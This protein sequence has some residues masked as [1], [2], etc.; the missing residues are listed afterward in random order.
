MIRPRSNVNV[1][2][3]L[4]RYVV[5]DKREVIGGAISNAGNLHAWCLRELRVD[6][7][8]MSRA[9]AAND[10]LTL[11]PFWVN[12]RAPTWPE[13][14][15]GVI[16]GLTQAAR[17]PQILRAATTSTFYRLAEILDLIEMSA[18]RAREIIVSG[19][20][21]HSLASLHLLADALGRDV[22]NCAELEASLH[23]AALHG[24]KKLGRSVSS[25][26]KGKT[27]RHNRA[28]AVQHRQRRERQIALE[29]LLS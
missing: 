7:I 20:G 27:I 18:G 24:L 8:D 25:T 17:A 9:A 5:D 23:G 3:G 15:Q 28:L 19:G 26:T 29:K 21:A 2:L 16:T 11:L 13:H 1:S 14:L 22:T 4:F 12:E 6:K 10:P